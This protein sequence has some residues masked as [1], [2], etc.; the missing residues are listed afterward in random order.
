MTQAACQTTASQLFTGNVGGVS[1]GAS[2]DG[3]QFGAAYVFQAQV[4]AQVF[5]SGQRNYGSAT[6]LDTTNPPSPTADFLYKFSNNVFDVGFAGF[7]SHVHGS[8]WT[9]SAS[10]SQE[11][12]PQHLCSP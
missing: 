7:G 6:V 3:T 11:Y 9:G 1:E 5:A 10:S 12:L 8:F 4:W 2:T